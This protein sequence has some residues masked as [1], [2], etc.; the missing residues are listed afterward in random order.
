M[1]AGIEKAW[2]WLYYNSC[3]YSNR[4]HVFGGIEYNFFRRIFT[5][6][7]SLWAVECPLGKS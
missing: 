1:Y 7:G 6:P 3:Q 2:K 5:R 4:N